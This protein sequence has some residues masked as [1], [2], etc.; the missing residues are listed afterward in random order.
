MNEKKGPNAPKEVKK[1]Q[2]NDDNYRHIVRILNTDLD[3]SKQTFMA[4]QKMK[5][6]GF[7]LSNAICEVAKIDKRRKAGYLTEKD[8]EA[9][10]AVLRNPM[11]YNIPEWMFN[12][13]KD[14]ETGDDIHMVGTD[15]TYTVQNDI[16]NMI[17][18]RIYRGT[19]HASHLPVRGQNTKSNFRKS[20]VKNAAKKKQ[21][22]QRKSE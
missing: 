1:V 8:V 14:P 4:L 7:M 19:R 17:R 9:I 22:P 18:L 15:L 3:G 11:A 13:R 16:K 5:G 6:I 21:R 2:Q 10:S 20:K 12:R